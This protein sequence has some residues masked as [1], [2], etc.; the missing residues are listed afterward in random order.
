MA[1]ENSSVSE[2]RDAGPR[3]RHQLALMLA[4]LSAIERWIADARPLTAADAAALTREMRL[5]LSR[6]MD[7]RRKEQEALIA[8]ADAHLAASGRVLAQHGTLRA[9]LAHRNEWLRTAVADRLTEHGVHIV[10]VFGDGAEAAGTLVAEQPDLVLV[11]DR[12][13]T[14]PGLEVVRRARE[15]APGALI[16]AHVLDGSGVD[17]MVAAGALAVF[18]RRIPPR[19]IADQL[20][21][22][23]SVRELVTLR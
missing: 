10:G 13:P 14:V 8:R 22:C 2:V 20:V 11:E 23:V 4:Q 18:T 19:E 12:L 17:Q 5:D 7:A 15:Y 9:V 16:G 1:R 6:R 3:P 21:E